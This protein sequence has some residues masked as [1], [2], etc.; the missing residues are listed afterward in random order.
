MAISRPDQTI[1]ALIGRMSPADAQNRLLRV[2]DTE[3]AV[4]LL[5]MNDDVR[6]RILGLAGAA[7]AERVRQVIDRHRHT[8]ISYENYLA[9]AE[10]MIGRLSSESSASTTPGAA[11]PP[12]SY[13]RPGRARR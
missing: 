10:R 12:R 5:H 1:V 4:G 6:D 3:F 8:R 9:A 11:A 7:K 13:Y 2:P